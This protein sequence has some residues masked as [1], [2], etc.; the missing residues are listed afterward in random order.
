ML[1]RS[2]ISI[3]KRLSGRVSF[4]RRMIHRSISSS[5]KSFYGEEVEEVNTA[6]TEAAL[7][8]D[9]KPSKPI[10]LTTASIV[11][12]VRDEC[13]AE[14][15]IYESPNAELNGAMPSIQMVLQLGS[16]RE[17]VA[18]AQALIK[19]VLI[20]QFALRELMTVVPP[21]GG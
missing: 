21:A 2:T 10:V 5:L 3:S 14:V 6:R 1:R 16:T 17:R 19:R 13:D 7:R 12:T 4:G 11:D 20:N 9:R 15:T 18:L 8:L